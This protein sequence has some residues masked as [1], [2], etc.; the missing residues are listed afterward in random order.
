MCVLR[1]RPITIG[2]EI[3]REYVRYAEEIADISYS[4]AETFSS[5]LLQPTS[6]SLYPIG[7]P[8]L[9]VRV[10]VV[11]AIIRSAGHV[12]NVRSIVKNICDK[13]TEIIKGNG[14]IL[15]IV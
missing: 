2:T 13:A 6:G 4:Q 12:V 11:Q 1:G 9:P 10:K 7:K 8:K 14:T 15:I 5:A 3:S